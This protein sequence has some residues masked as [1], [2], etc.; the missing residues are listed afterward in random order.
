M[1]W[2]FLEA[3]AVLSLS[4]EASAMNSHYESQEKD[5]PE[6]DEDKEMIGIVG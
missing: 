3:W 2:I 4:G 6:K 5:S 1:S